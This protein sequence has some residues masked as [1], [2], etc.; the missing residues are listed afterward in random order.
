MEPTLEAWKIVRR[1]FDYDLQ[2]EMEEKKGSE[3][4]TT[5]NVD[6]SDLPVYDEEYTP[7][8]RH[9]LSLT[10]FVRNLENLTDDMFGEHLAKLTLMV[11]DHALE[12]ADHE[13]LM[14]DPAECPADD[15]DPFEQNDAISY[16]N[17][18][19]GEQEEQQDEADLFLSLKYL[20]KPVFL[21]VL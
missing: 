13:R 2:H 10:M 5:E 12:F 6:L 14:H 3:E 21:E 1:Y 7:V 15:V 9:Q 17:A 16:T 19:T 4:A 8:T 18:L 20:Q 11:P